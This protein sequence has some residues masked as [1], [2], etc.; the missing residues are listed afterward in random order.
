MSEISDM[1]QRLCP[2]GVEYR[3]LVS[4]AKVQYGYPF[5]SKLFTDNPSFIPLIRIRDVKSGLAGTYYSGPILS[6]YIVC[7]GDILVGMDGEFNLGKWKD[8]DSLLN[9]RVCKITSL[10]SNIVLD[11]FLYHLLLPL[12]KKVEES[13][14]GSTVKHLSAKVINA[15]EIPVPP[16]EV[17]RKIVEVLDNFSELT[18]ELT[19]ELEA[20]K[21]QYEYYRDNL[22]NFSQIAPQLGKMDEDE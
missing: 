4:V 21:K 9:Q 20:R 11:G 2:D 16:L 7:A 18:A 3:K 1:I 6:D 17:Q 12:F 10:D 8:R 5:D 19:A 15:L 13:I 14:S 22:L